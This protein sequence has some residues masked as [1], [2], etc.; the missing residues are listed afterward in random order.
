MTSEFLAQERADYEL[1]KK[2]IIG[3]SVSISTFFNPILDVNSV[4]GVTDKFFGF[5]QERFLIQSISYSL[6]YSPSMNITVSNLN[7]FAFLTKGGANKL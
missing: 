5:E 4:V 3:S 7:N 2:L 1:R 6:D